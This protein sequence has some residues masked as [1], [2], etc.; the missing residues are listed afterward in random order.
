MIGSFYRW[1]GNAR[2]NE[3][4]DLLR[5]EGRYDEGV[6]KL[7]KAEFFFRRAQFT[8]GLAD[9]GDQYLRLRH[10]SEAEQLFDEAKDKDGL[11]AVSEALI[12]RG[13][14]ASA[15]RVRDLAQQSFKEEEYRRI[16]DTLLE[17]GYLMAAAEAYDRGKDEDGI[18]RAAEKLLDRGN[19]P[20]AEL[21]MRYLGR[22]VSKERW[23]AVGEVLLDRAEVKAAEQAFK[24]A[25]SSLD[26]G[27][28]QRAGQ[29]YMT[30]GRL[31]AA[32][33]AF[34]RAG[35]RE[36]LEQLAEAAGAA[37]YFELF[38]LAAK[39]AGRDVDRQA[40]AAM[41]NDY[42]ARGLFTQADKAFKAAGEEQGLQRVAEATLE[43]G[44]V[45][46]ALSR[47]VLAEMKEK[48]GELLKD[49]RLYSSGLAMEAAGDKE[50][51]I[52]LGEIYAQKGALDGAERT[53]RKAG[54]PIEAGTYKE[55]GD[56][57]EKKG[58]ALSASRAMTRTGTEEDQEKLRTAAERY[59]D[60][61]LIGSAERSLGLIEDR[62]GL[63]K[64]GDKYLEVGDF[65]SADRLYR[66]AGRETSDTEYQRIGDDLLERGWLTSADWSRKRRGAP[67][68][69]EEYRSMGERFLEQGFLYGAEW[70]FS[71]AGDT[72]GLLKAGQAYLDQADLKG[73]ERAFKKA[74]RRMSSSQYIA[75]G[76]RFLQNGYLGAARA[77]FEA[78][79]DKEGK[80]RLAKAL[81]DQGD[82]ITAEKV[83]QDV[84]K[85]MEVPEYLEYGRRY[86]DKGNLS[87]AAYAFRRANSQDELRATGEAL[88]KAGRLDEA[89]EVFRAGHIRFG[90]F[91]RLMYRLRRRPD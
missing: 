68:D 79:D 74:E 24:R 62:A 28:L 57:W 36:G 71:R 4:R 85:A 7:R 22:E 81:A 73:S 51:L 19:L 75:L 34:D 9:L 8:D 46:R 82:I 90:L 44:D 63:A 12:E 1:L 41:A 91:S 89:I 83:C 61:G 53:F 31:D 88:L 86:L 48:G 5:C 65:A 50:G 60:E 27:R 18:A 66:A 21:L 29:R 49:G 59:L 13:N 30:E 14:L 20:A 64:I 39:K 6:E 23:E 87:A 37:G 15:R 52:R 43:R 84:G 70:S 58:Y 42:L 33:Y 56:Q 17:R 55:W 76:D 45:R 2:F 69:K 11:L 78:A 26:S 77:A 25:G 35:D 47:G 10:L 32:L 38:L 80:L 3:A 72:D 16:G 67:M 54:V 40:L